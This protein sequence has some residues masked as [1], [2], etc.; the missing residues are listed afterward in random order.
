MHGQPRAG[1][2]PVIAASHALIDVR[3]NRYLHLVE[4]DMYV[5]MY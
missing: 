4:V 5:C 2:P 3:A 1:I